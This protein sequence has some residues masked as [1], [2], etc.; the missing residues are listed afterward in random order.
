[1]RQERSPGPSIR[2]ISGANWSGPISQL[3]QGRAG[4]NL[5]AQNPEKI[6]PSLHPEVNGSPLAPGHRTATTACDI[7][8]TA[9]ANF[10]PVASSRQGVASF[11]RKSLSCRA[12]RSRFRRVLLRESPILEIARSRAKARCAGSPNAGGRTGS[13]PTVPGVNIL[14]Q[15]WCVTLGTE[16][17]YWD[18]KHFLSAGLTHD[19]GAGSVMIS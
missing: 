16:A 17:R 12:T 9:I 8:V 14:N 15:S 3:L 11:C 5:L 19:S 10:D 2:S 18:A 6:R 7:S 1:M 13:Q 4:R